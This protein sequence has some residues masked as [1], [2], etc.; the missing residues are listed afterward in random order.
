[1]TALP[2]LDDTD[3]MMVFADLLS[4]RGDPRGDLIQLQLA[5]E[6]RPTDERL[7]K[8]EAQHLARNDRALLGG[9][10]TATSLCE[11]TWCRGYV[12]Q[13][14]LQSWVGALPEWARTARPPRRGQQ[15]PRRSRSSAR[16]EE[17]SPSTPRLP[18]L[19]R[20]LLALESARRLQRLTV[21][22]PRS[23][24]ADGVLEAC[25]SEVARAAH[26][27]L[28]SLA[29]HLVEPSWDQ[30]EERWEVRATTDFTARGGLSVSV[31]STV[32]AQVEAALSSRR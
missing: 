7:A 8:A 20:E 30:W 19:V 16:Q 25:A 13:A 3:A 31:S 24:S 21:S 32:A 23:A 29:L 17:A 5:R 1:M 10:R 6:R 27:E 15:R 11:L 18:R 22:L 9:L 4:V 2:P 28:Q 14:Q 26:V 12:V